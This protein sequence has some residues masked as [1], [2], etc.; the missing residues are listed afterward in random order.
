VLGRKILRKI[1]GLTKEDNGIWGIKTN[2]ELDEIIKERIIINCVKSQ[3]LSWVGHIN[4]MPE[5]SIV[6][7]IY[8][9]KP[10]TSRPVMKAQVRVGR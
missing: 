1:F 9:W 10:F 5:T 7:K 2:K 8:K 6:R 4:R 3:L